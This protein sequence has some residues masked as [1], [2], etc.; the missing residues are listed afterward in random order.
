[1]NLETLYPL[2]TRNQKRETSS[3]DPLQ[4]SVNKDLIRRGTVYLFVGAGLSFFLSATHTWFYGWL[5]TGITL[6]ADVASLLGLA[7]GLGRREPWPRTSLPLGR[8]V[9]HL[10]LWAAAALLYGW[11]SACVQLLRSPA[12]RD[13]R[14]ERCFRD[15]YILWFFWLLVGGRLYAQVL[16]MSWYRM[17]IY[18]VFTIGKD[19]AGS[20]VAGGG[21]T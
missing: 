11:F 17:K 5:S 14:F 10:V 21:R 7:G 9:L 3:V 16:G 6:L 20:P 1:M 4:P 19:D 2:E 15:A 13:A 18:N 8:R 12:V